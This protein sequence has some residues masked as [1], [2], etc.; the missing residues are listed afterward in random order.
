M[1][2]PERE[3]LQSEAL[4]RLLVENALV[5]IYILQDSRIVY[6]NP[7]L[8]R[9]LGFT[10]EE[11]R[12][13][14][15]FDLAVPEDRALIA[16]KIRARE[17]GE[18]EVAHYC[19]RAQ[20][21]DKR[22][23]TL[24]VLG[25]RT[26]WDGRPAI[27]GTALDV[28]EHKQIEQLRNRLLSIG[29]QILQNTS[30]KVI[31][32]EVV[33]ALAAHSKFR[34]IGFSLYAV[35]S[36]WERSEPPQI[37][38]YLTAGLTTEEE[39]RIRQ[40]IAKNQIISDRRILEAGQPLGSAL[41]VTPERMPELPQYS[42][43]LG[44]AGQPWGPHDTLYILLRA[45]ER[46]LGRV[47]LADPADGQIP[48]VEEIEA[49][50]LLI[51]M[52]TLAVHNARQ[53]RELREQRQQMQSLI[54]FLQALNQPSS[55]TELLEI[56]IREGLVLLPKANAGSFL[57]L[58]MLTNCFQY[59]AAVGRNLTALQKATI[60]YD[61]IANAL[62][63]ERGPRILT[64][65]LQ[66]DHAVTQ[67]LFLKTGVSVPASTLVLPLHDH[68]GRIIGLLNINHLSEEGIFGQED[69][70]KLVA[71]RPQLELALT[72]ERERAHLKEL[73]KL[74][75]M[76]EVYNRRALEEELQH[77]ARAK[78]SFALVFI[79]I[80]DFYEINDRFGH[81][82]GDQII[83]ELADF[84]KHSVRAS[85][86][87]YRYGG[88]EFIV[89]ME[90]TNRVEAERVMM[91]LEERLRTLRAQWS[92]RLQGLDI[93]IS[94]GVSDWSPEAPRDLKAVLEEADQFMYRR[95]RAKKTYL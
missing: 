80:D 90:G 40:N 34:K 78:R 12:G 21:K 47:A 48:S 59:K 74:D 36:S 50:V 69:L 43:G 82:E 29:T 23:I 62:G 66:M 89:L 1:R 56:V 52:A 87:V 2:D 60:P 42:A 46:I 58:D 3:L 79:D 68:D 16:E 83:Q 35:P 32:Q 76:T 27:L 73:T 91:R 19:F 5:G 14:P 81:L 72:R 17:S 45:G 4:F 30:I 88:D 24:E 85:D 25:R 37:A 77:F 39:Q 13:R 84:L 38:D 53:F 28:T 7:T 63:L 86:G 22:V 9:I 92:A 49:L 15:V 70:E 44:A 57:L 93:T 26:E 71:L 6:I 65:S 33:T 54:S 20:S 67:E 75:A 11:L 41:L 64:R 18:L 61:H 31:L 55:L 8:E 51:N 10:L 94:L 95:K